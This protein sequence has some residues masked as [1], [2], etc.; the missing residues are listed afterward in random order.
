MFNDITDVQKALIAHAATQNNGLVAVIFAV[1]FAAGDFD[2]VYYIYNSKELF[3]LAN[4]ANDEEIYA[5]A[6]ALGNALHTFARA[7]AEHALN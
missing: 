1:A 5:T 3:T 4:F 2:T 6:K 7:E